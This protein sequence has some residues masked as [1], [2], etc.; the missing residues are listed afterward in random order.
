MRTGL[1][2][3]N[4]RATAFLPTEAALQSSVVQGL[5]VL[6]YT[7]METGLPTRKTKCPKCTFWFTPKT[8]KLNTPGTPDLYVSHVKWGVRWQ[9]LPL[10]IGLECKAP[11]GRSLFGAVQPGT[12]KPEQRELA[13]LGLT[14]LIHSWDETLAALRRVEAIIG[15]EVVSRGVR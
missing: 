8:G 11:G 3:L 4:K 12:V 13:N 10:W 2:K 7:V 5:R 6:G 15:V 9:G 14:V 1:A